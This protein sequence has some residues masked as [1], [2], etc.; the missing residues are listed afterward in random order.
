VIGGA[1]MAVEVSQI[2]DVFFPGL[3][4][5]EGIGAGAL[6]GGLIGAWAYAA[7]HASAAH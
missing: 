7:S 4:I 5:A 3:V 1:V 2:D 6:G